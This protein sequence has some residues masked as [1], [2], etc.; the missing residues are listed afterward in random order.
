LFG[1]WSPRFKKKS[2]QTQDL[3]CWDKPKK[4]ITHDIHEYF[5]N[6]NANCY[7]PFQTSPI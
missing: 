6:M 5:W 2:K 4:C 3:T 1:C 7:F